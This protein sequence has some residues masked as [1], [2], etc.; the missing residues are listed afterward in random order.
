MEKEGQSV[1]DDKD[2]PVL[3]LCVPTL[4]LS[5]AITRR[6]RDVGLGLYPLFGEHGDEGS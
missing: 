3:D 6:S 2:V 5:S 1:Y 4:T